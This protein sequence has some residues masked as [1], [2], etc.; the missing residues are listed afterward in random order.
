MRTKTLF[1]SV[2][3]DITSVGDLPEDLARLGEV[4]RER[5]SH[6]IPFNQPQRCAFRLLRRLFGED[7]RVAAWTRTWRCR[8]QAIII[9]NGETFEHCNRQKCLEWERQKLETML[10]ME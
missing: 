7:G 4:K 3:G 8:W 6:I 5:A 2:G 10:T 1:V 9:A